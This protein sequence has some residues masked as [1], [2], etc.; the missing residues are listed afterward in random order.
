[1]TFDWRDGIGMSCGLLGQLLGM[2][3]FKFHGAHCGFSLLVAAAV[4]AENFSV[5]R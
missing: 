5:M 3:R 4:S 2:M 1:V